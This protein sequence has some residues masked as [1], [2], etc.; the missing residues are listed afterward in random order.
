ML[1]PKRNLIR[2]AFVEQNEFI[3]KGL[4]EL[5]NQPMVYKR[6]YVRRFNNYMYPL[7]QYDSTIGG[8]GQDEGHNH[9]QLSM[10]QSPGS[11]KE[12]VPGSMKEAVSVQSHNLLEHKRPVIFDPFDTFYS[13][14][15]PTSS[16]PVGSNVASLTSLDVAPLGANTLNVDL[17]LDNL[18]V[19]QNN[20]IWG[21]SGS[22]QTI[23]D[24]TVWG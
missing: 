18:V 1:Y 15:S 24:A 13:R 5:P 11:M 2:E 20:N 7:Y 14:S 22:N 19:K 4:I 17:Q 23:S 16:K 3:D 10:E 9:P 6:K 21:T 8:Q 12:V